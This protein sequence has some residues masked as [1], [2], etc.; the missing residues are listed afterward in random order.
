MKK[1]ALILI[2]VFCVTEN[3]IGQETGEEFTPP[4]TEIIIIQ[5]ANPGYA[6]YR[7]QDSNG[8]I[9]ATFCFITFRKNLVTNMYFGVYD[10]IEPINWGNFFSTI[11]NSIRSKYNKP[12]NYRDW[13]DEVNYLKSLATK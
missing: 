7:L 10:W 13:E 1:L 5:F 3:A 4:F 8:S 11:E 2:L 9:A 6:A 12:I